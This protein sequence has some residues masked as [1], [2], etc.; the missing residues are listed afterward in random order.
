MLLLDTCAVIWIA[1]GD[2]IRRPASGALTEPSRPDL[3]IFVSPM[4][5]WEIAML[6]AK[7]RISLS[8]NPEIWFDRFC[9]LPG[10]TLARMPPSVLVASCSLPGSPPADPVDR[11]LAAT[12]R[13][14]GYTLV[15]RDRRLL[16]YGAEGHVRAMEC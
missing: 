7:N 9:A 6:A 5:A 16:D 3:A 15:T 11:I 8:L 12:A 4:T 13:A 2:P 14:F 1:H 10:V